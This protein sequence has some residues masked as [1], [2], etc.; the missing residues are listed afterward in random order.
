MGTQVSYMA[1]R[2]V[3]GFLGAGDKIGIHFRK[4][5][6][7]QNEED[8]KALLDFAD[9]QFFGK[10]VETRFDRMAFPNAPKAFTWSAPR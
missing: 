9:L 5:K 7:A 10:K 2:Q 4:G 6:H 3:Y 1:A 8:W